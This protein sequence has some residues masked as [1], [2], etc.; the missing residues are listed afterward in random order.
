M[1][2]TVNFR[3]PGRSSTSKIS[4]S[5]K[6]RKG[7]K[8]RGRYTKPNGEGEKI[9]KGSKITQTSNFTV[10]AYWEGKHTIT[11]NAN[12]GV[13]NKK[14]GIDKKTKQKYAG[15]TYPKISKPKRDGYTFEGW[16]DA[17]EGGNKVELN[18][19]SYKIQEDITLYAH[20]IDNIKPQKFTIS[21]ENLTTEG[22]SMNLSRQI[23]LGTGIADVKY[24]VNDT[25]S[26][27][28]YQTSNEVSGLSKDMTKYVWAEL[29]DKAGNT[30][31]STNYVKVVTAHEH[32]D[33]CYSI[34]GTT[35]TFKYDGNKNTG[36][37]WAYYRCDT[38]GIN[39]TSKFG[40]IKT[41]G[42]EG[43]RRMFLGWKR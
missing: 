31:R 5:L 8:Y 1:G 22:F 38:C 29:T 37:S 28:T 34:T 15:E 26:G 27:S 12:E 42:T 13:F 18:N 24:Y 39:L 32:T 21:V 40:I 2:S 23:D 4:L 20:W 7:Y 6:E 3:M 41:Y 36:D 19:A 17:K 11:Y 16:Y 35:Y 33:S 14:T 25:T 43:I 9:E 10:Y 30:R